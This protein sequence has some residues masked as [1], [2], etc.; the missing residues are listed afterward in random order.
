MENHSLLGRPCL[1]ANTQILKSFFK[2]MDTVSYWLWKTFRM[3]D[4]L[5]ECELWGE[6]SKDKKTFIKFLDISNNCLC[7]NTIKVD[8]IITSMK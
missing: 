3:T 1:K 4:K 8:E 7:V 6:K 5:N 2:S